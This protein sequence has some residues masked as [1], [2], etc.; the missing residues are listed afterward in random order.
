MSDIVIPAECLPVPVLGSQLRATLDA[1]VSLQQRSDR[2]QAPVPGG[3]GYPSQAQ[4]RVGKQRTTSL[5][6]FFA[7]RFRNWPR[8]RKPS[9]AAPHTCCAVLAAIILCPL[10]GCKEKNYTTTYR[11]FSPSGKKVALKTYSQQSP[12][13]YTISIQ[14]RSSQVDLQP[15]PV[16]TGFVP[17]GYSGADVTLLSWRDD[18]HLDI[19]SPEGSEVTAGRE[20]V[21]SLF[22]TYNRYDP[23]SSAASK[24]AEIVQKIRQIT[25]ESHEKSDGKLL[26]CSIVVQ[27]TDAQKS[28][29]I[30]VILNG[31]GVKLKDLQGE[32]GTFSATF[33][34]SYAPNGDRESLTLTQV[35]VDG[36]PMSVD[37]LVPAIGPV[38]DATTNDYVSS[39]GIRLE[40]PSEYQT[41]K[42]GFLQPP[43]IS[44]IF[45]RLRRGTLSVTYKLGRND[46]SMT[47]KFDGPIDERTARTYQECEAKA[48][49]F[50][51]PVGSTLRANNSNKEN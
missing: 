29:K 42:Y 47:Y 12:F 44:S 26:N 38:Q 5:P 21:G 20:N 19:L 4:G 27:G 10:I 35:Y 24:D 13:E 15:T 45:D 28:R 32:F 36:I 25:Y 14:D 34:M 43:V 6:F 3:H 23:K 9:R 41:V 30:G 46:Q 40:G 48:R 49:I 50:L 8:G 16:M 17:N 1:D 31:V 37:H 39:L 22:I 51:H 7:G 18:S 33:F 11:V 2:V